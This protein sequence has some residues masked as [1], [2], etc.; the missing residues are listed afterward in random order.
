MQINTAL[1][2][3]GEGNRIRPFRPITAVLE[4]PRGIDPVIALEG[5]IEEKQ[6]QMG[7]E[8]YFVSSTGPMESLLERF[9]KSYIRQELRRC[10]DLQSRN[11]NLRRIL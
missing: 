1:I 8:F 11:S 5:Y 3:K 7:R 10:W 9:H 2:L 4:I 6:Y